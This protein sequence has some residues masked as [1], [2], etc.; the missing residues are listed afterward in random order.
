MG[1]TLPAVY[2][3]A[4]E[5][6]VAAFIEGRLSFPGIWQ[7][8]ARTMDAHRAR[9]NANLETIL[10]ADAWARATAAAVLESR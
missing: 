10:S 1:G 3:A 7:T 2:N 9:T 4:N 6:A 8:V 5:I